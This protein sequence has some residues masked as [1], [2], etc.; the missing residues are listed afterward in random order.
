MVSFLFYSLDESFAESASIDEFRFFASCWE[1]IL[2]TFT[3]CVIRCK[4]EECTVD[5]LTDAVECR[6]C[7]E[8][9]QASQ[10][11]MFDGSIK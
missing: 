7:R 8:I 4:C 11:L 6:C 3:F 5:Y 2:I 9:A 1:Y 10:K